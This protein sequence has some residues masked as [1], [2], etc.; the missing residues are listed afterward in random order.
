MTST[1]QRIRSS[2]NDLEK[3]IGRDIC[4]SKQRWKVAVPKRSWQKCPSPCL[5]T[6]VLVLLCLQDHAATPPQTHPILRSYPPAP[7]LLR[8]GRAFPSH[9]QRSLSGDHLDTSSAAKRS[10][11]SRV[12]LTGKCMSSDLSAYIC[13]F[14]GCT[15]MLD[16]YPS[17]KP[18]AEHEFTE[19][20]CHHFFQ[21]HDCWETFTIEGDAHTQRSH[22]S[23]QHA[24]RMRDRSTRVFLV[25]RP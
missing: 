1:G 25:R 9:L 22:H 3:R 2:S 10:Q 6:P 16:T 12:E 13:T 19:H 11:Q 24:R 18:W 15:K 17:R 7:M 5:S 23:Q 8:A 20:R 21:C 14:E 4:A